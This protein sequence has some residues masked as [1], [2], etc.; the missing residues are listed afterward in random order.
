MIEILN[1]H[2]R[3]VIGIAVF[4]DQHR[5]FAER[6]LHAHA[7]GGIFEIDRTHV[8]LGCEA[9]QV[10]RDAD[11]AGERR[12]RAGTQDHHG[13]I[14]PCNRGAMNSPPLLLGQPK[15]LRPHAARTARAP[16]DP[17]CGID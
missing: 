5:N 9:Q 7:V 3:V 14:I 8:D 2:R 16:D 12:S 4:G 13:N 6:I 11:F 1:N 10:C 17:G 15:I